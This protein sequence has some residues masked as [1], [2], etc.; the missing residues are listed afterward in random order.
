MRVHRR[1]NG[2][3]YSNGSLMLEV[4]LRSSSCII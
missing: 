4:M 3:N 2:D 1:L